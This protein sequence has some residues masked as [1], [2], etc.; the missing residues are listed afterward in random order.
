MN[1]LQIN[2]G[3]DFLSTYMLEIEIRLSDFKP[4]ASHG[5]S[6]LPFWVHSDRKI[7]VLESLINDELL[8]IDILEDGEIEDKY[9]PVIGE[10]SEQ[11]NGVGKESEVGHNENKE[12]FLTSKASN[13]YQV[14]ASAVALKDMSNKF[15]CDIQHIPL[16]ISTDSHMETSLQDIMESNLQYT[17]SKPKQNCNRKTGSQTIQE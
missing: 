6:L 9:V 14:D 10:L 4:L 16:S 11:H 3:Q 7:K 12:S 8:Q 15:S 2:T 17:M 13:G 1:T 5:S